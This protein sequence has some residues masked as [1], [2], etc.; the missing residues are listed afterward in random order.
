GASGLTARPERETG[1]CRGVAM[2]EEA[3]GAREKTLSDYD[4]LRRARRPTVLLGFSGERNWRLEIPEKGRIVLGR[5]EGCDI[6]IKDARVSRNHCCLHVG[7]N[8]LLED[9]GSTTGTRLMGRRLRPGE[10]T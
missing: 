4:E 9:L 8:V 5:G 2:E 1:R 6:V 10:K 7:S 3:S